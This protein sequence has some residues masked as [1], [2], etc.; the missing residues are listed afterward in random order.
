[1][2]VFEVS[3]FLVEKSQRIGADNVLCAQECGL[4]CQIVE[5]EEKK[6][7][8]LVIFIHSKKVSVES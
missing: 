8:N 1:M 3:S 2:P 6:L 4:H 7:Q 5:C